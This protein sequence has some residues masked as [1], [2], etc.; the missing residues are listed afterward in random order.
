MGARL[1][2]SLPRVASRKKT[3]VPLGALLL[4][5]SLLTLG[6]AARPAEPTA[7]R[8][9]E[10]GAASAPQAGL[11]LQASYSSPVMSQSPILLA[12]EAG[13]F[14]EQG[15]EV[16]ISSVRQATQNAAALM[17]GE[18]DVSVMGG[19]APLR[20]RL[21]GAELV[22]V[23]GTKPYF[24]G[25]VVARPE[26][27]TPADLRGKRLGVGSKGGNPDF[28]AR[29]ML[30][31][32]GLEPDRDVALLTTGGDPE[33]VAALVAGSVDAGAVIPP[34]DEQ[35]RNLGFH[36][37]I[38]VTAARVPFPATVL[39]TGSATLASR[40]DAIER[41]LRAYAQASH[42]FVRDRD[43][44]LRVG[45][46]FTGRDDVAA[47]EL[48]YD[49]ERQII[50]PDLDLPLTAIQGALDL[51]RDEDPRA[52][53]ARPDDFVDLRLLR[54]IKESGFLDRLAADAGPR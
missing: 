13:Y 1:R 32:L 35:A 2:E 36:N 54:Q 28:M 38:D 17:S 47:I 49:V 27:A 24:A 31:R 5:A 6:C 44:A 45:A 14:A 39:A 29:A 23:G 12:Q 16:A 8:A 40:P 25:A 26:I 50:Q 43:F 4:I 20:A 42:R 33:T 41:F 46:A 19:T 11:T 37:L 30:P 9:V 48:A 22:I 53:D 52:A 7:P 15:L 10:T 21:G 51:M 18:L 34:G 3:M